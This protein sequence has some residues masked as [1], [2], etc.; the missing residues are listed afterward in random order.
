MAFVSSHSLAM[1][2][3]RSRH[4]VLLRL[5]M[6][7]GWFVDRWFAAGSLICCACTLLY[8]QFVNH[9]GHQRSPSG[10]MAGADAGAIVAMKIFVKQN[11]IAPVRVSL[12][13]LVPAKHRTPSI[14]IALES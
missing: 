3:S 11:V 1:E 9:L 13:L 7:V 5:I 8:S 10:L 14:F 4:S 6:I 12:E 2:A